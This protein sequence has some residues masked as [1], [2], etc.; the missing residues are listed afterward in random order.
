MRDRL[1]I[2]D[3]EPGVRSQI[4]WGLIDEFDIEESG[5]LEESLRKFR[6]FRPSVVTLDIR[7]DGPD[8]AAG[9]DLLWRLL[10]E[11]PTLKVIM[12]TADTDER[13]ATRAL[14]MGAWDYYTKPI[15][16]DELRLILARAARVRRLQSAA[17][18]LSAGD[19]DPTRFSS[20]LG[21]S[22]Q[23]RRVE[24]LLITLAQGNDP[25]LVL[26]ENGTGRDIAARALHELGP[27]AGHPFTSLACAER[28]PSHDRLPPAGTVFLDE[29]VGLDRMDQERLPEWIE[30][31]GE[32]H[33]VI[34][35]AP[36][37]LPDRVRRGEFPEPSYHF[38]GALTVVLP[39]LRERPADTLFLAR[40]MI[41][42]IG[43]RFRARARGLTPEAERAL[44]RS[45]WPGNFRELEKRILGAVLLADTD[46]LTPEDLWLSRSPVPGGAL[47]ASLDRVERELVERA[48]KAHRGNVSRASSD[49]AVSRQTMHALVKKHEIDLRAYR[50]RVSH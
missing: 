38:L 1:L 12:V 43:A 44:A 30:G 3:D 5:S 47:R 15:V 10:T 42:S 8:C 29:V 7:L 40:Q 9:L 18:R 17:N 36:E 50:A 37:D 6:E 48:L 25:V 32:R 4:R 23:A 27:T 22:P 26:G 33:R 14:E 16:T 35:S 49:L 45:P 20:W 31:I 24:R 46:L 11:D 39:P 2:V 13:T 34:V 28:L 19:A 21:V 41:S